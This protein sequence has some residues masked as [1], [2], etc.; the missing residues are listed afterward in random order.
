MIKASK[1]I[2]L[3]LRES[4]KIF[5]TKLIVGGQLYF[6]LCGNVVLLDTSRSPDR[7]KEIILQLYQVTIVILK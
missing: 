7:V 6:L 5:H 4:F 3:F 2:N 1:I